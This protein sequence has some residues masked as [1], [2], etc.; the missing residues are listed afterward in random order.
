MTSKWLLGLILLLSAV[1]PLL[2]GDTLID[3]RENWNAIISRFHDH[4]ERNRRLQD[5]IDGFVYRGMINFEKHFA[6]TDKRMRELRFLVSRENPN[7][8]FAVAMYC[9]QIDDLKTFV[10]QRVRRAKV[11]RDKLYADSTRIRSLEPLLKQ[12]T[13]KDLKPR[14][15]DIL[16]TCEK[17]ILAFSGNISAV[18]DRIDNA[19]KEGVR[20]QEEIDKLGQFAEDKRK[21]VIR[22]VI[23]ARQLS[24]RYVI[25][26]VGPLLEFWMADI[27]EWLSIQFPDDPKF[28][29]YFLLLL[30]FPGLPVF[31]LGRP[32]FRR[33]VPAIGLSETHRNMK[34][35]LLS[36][37][38]IILS[39]FFMGS[40]IVLGEVESTPM[41]QIGK[42]L[43]C[44]AAMLLSLSLR[45]GRKDLPRCLVLYTPLLFQ[46]LASIVLCTTL[47]PYLPLILICPLLNL[48]VIGVTAWLLLTRRYPVPDTVFSLLTVAGSTVSLILA[49]IGLPY[50]AFT[51]MLVWFVAVAGL[52]SGMA[53]TRLV[54]DFS[55]VNSHRKIFTCML[56]TLLVPIM[57]LAIIGATVYWTSGM[58]NAQ[59][60][61]IRSLFVDM[62]NC[63]N[64]IRI[65]LIDILACVVGGLVLHFLISSGRHLIRLAYGDKAETGLIPSFLILGTYIS[66]S[67][68]VIVV[69]LIFDFHY[70]SIL[71]IM[72]GMSMGLGFGL[73]DILGNFISGVS[74]LVGQHLRPGDI[75]EYNGTWGKIRKI[76]AR[77]TVVETGDL[78]VITFPNSTVMSK[79]FRNWTSNNNMMIR[80]VKVSVGHGSDIAKVKELLLQTAHETAGVLKS[81]PPLVT[82]SELTDNTMQF[83]LSIAVQVAIR[84]EVPGRIR[85]RIEQVLRDN[86]INIGTTKKSDS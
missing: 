38:L 53:I 76:N 41:F 59:H 22:Q 72:G 39:V 82:L 13:R 80:E 55:A 16:Q 28:W 4:L 10:D 12:V 69:L 86:G 2:H 18:C 21:T 63:R 66:W 64:L 32:L 44:C 42:M 31:L 62:F 46:H 68:Y 11:L 15:F 3:E 78:A 45:V 36:W 25:P 51:I 57:W 50:V 33:I 8:V 71:V 73:K 58:Y 65:S 70:S 9:K 34:I 49:L 84:S 75:I 81:P 85:E 17:E 48:P 47:I 77:A 56:F 37:G 61:L 7:N 6:M 67:F 43:L 1:A 20:L 29:L 5:D 26:L 79:D 35:F 30:L 74:L 83:T 19:L 52:E 54:N 27:A 23:F 60:V 14:E 24:F 40:K